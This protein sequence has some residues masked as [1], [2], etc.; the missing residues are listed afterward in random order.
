MKRMTPELIYDDRKDASMRPSWNENK[1]YISEEHRHI[2]EQTK[3]IPGWQMEG[4][5]YKLYEMGYFAGDI[6]L[7]IGTFG[8]RSAVI[9]LKG[10]IGNKGRSQG[11]QFFGIDIE[12]ESIRRTYHTLTLHGGLIE[13]SLL[14]H[15]NLNSFF[16]KFPLQPTMVFLDGDHRYEG[17]REDLQ[18]LSRVLEPGIPVLC[19]DYLNP[20]NDT[21]EYGVRKAATEWEE[22]G[23][24]TFC[25]VFGC[26]ALFVTGE[27]CNGV[28]NLV[29]SGEEF[30]RRK[31]ALLASYGLIEGNSKGIRG[32][33]SFRMSQS[34]LNGHGTPADSLSVPQW[35][36]GRPEKNGIVLLSE[37]RH[38]GHDE[39]SYDAQ[40]RI[41][42][43]DAQAG[44]G[45]LSVL[46]A[47][48]A[49]FSLPALEIGCGTGKLSLGLVMEKAYPFLLLTD[50]SLGF[51]NILRDK[52]WQ[53]G[54]NHSPVYLAVLQAEEMNRLPQKAFSLIALRSTLHH[55]LDVPRFIRDA[56]NLLI[57][58]GFLAFEEPCMEGFVLM[59]A[60]AQ[61]LPFVLEKSCVSLDEGHKAKLMDFVETMKY[62][63]RRDLDKKDAEDKHLFRADEIMT[64]C[65]SEGFLAECFPNM[66]FDRYGEFGEFS[67]N[68][69]SFHDFFR[70]Y[71]KY[72]MG[73]DDP[74]VDIF[75]NHFKPYN[76]FIED[77]SAKNNSPYCY[78]VFLCRKL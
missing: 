48:G 30:L 56:S 75:E 74:F 7:E 57:S 61:F 50:L 60:M 68:L 2:F 40:Y 29:M 65:R 73:F 11:P 34:K 15:G 47:K 5:S 72:C 14:Y 53:T 62:Y 76:Q 41:D 1:G 69:F 4:D 18:C 12:M 3:D 44:R 39:M 66:T 27:R 6:I 51:L 64:I 17:V 71:L 55:V 36:N 16:S 28:G 32:A 46:R 52:L 67:D 63:A 78:S 13:H 42:P 26:S 21:G 22:A 59:G 35:L 20:E 19:H 38:F 54:P 9:E 31:D 25:G 23:F 49:D 43:A 45:L 24:L 10:A 58:G 77:I 8:G 33:R 37:P 70:D